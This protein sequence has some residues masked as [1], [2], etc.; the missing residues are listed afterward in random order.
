MSNRKKSY[1]ARKKAH[2]E[3]Q[4]DIR[5]EGERTGH[6]KE[7]IQHNQRQAREAIRESDQK[8]GR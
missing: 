7:Q 1:D 3:I 8:N 6:T 2:D 5:R 4:R